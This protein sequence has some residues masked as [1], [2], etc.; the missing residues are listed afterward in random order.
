MG[1]TACVIASGNFEVACII[2]ARCF[3]GCLVFVALDDIFQCC[4][5]FPFVAFIVF[6]TAERFVSD[7]V[8]GAGYSESEVE[9]SI[10]ALQLETSMTALELVTDT[11][12]LELETE[13]D[14]SQEI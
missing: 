7:Q 8:Q 10:V 1:M 13:M 11:A 3:N 12:P 6:G 2:A 5:C 14:V 4:G 9:T